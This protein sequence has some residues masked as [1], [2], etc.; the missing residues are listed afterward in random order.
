MA[1]VQRPS[2]LIKSGGKRKHLFKRG[3]LDLGSECF[4]EADINYRSK[5]IIRGYFLL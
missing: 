2:G 5:F 1:C 3:Y 4:V